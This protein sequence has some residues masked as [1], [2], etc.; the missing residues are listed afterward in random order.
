[1]EQLKK[2]PFLIILPLFFFLPAAVLAQEEAPLN[3][4]ETVDYSSPAREEF[5]IAPAA[6]TLL[7]G[8]S[9][10]AYGGGLTL[11]YGTGLSFGIKLL[12]A[13]DSETFFCTEILFFLRYYL[14][15]FDA[16][17]GPYVQINGGPV[18]F[19]DSRPDVSGYGTVS[20]G[21]TAGWRFPLG[22]RWFM[23]PFVRAGYPYII[24]AGL[25]GGMRF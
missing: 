11:G 23:E 2:H 22:N 14:Y 20:A 9:G 18:I 7:Y 19:G 4:P 17:T 10:L 21:L 12:V 16:G 15:F 25:S 3:P 24:G 6:E 13:V 5:F 1:M 8:R